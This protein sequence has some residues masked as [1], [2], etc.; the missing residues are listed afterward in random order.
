MLILAGLTYLIDFSLNRSSSRA[1]T[2]PDDDLFPR[3]VGF[4]DLV[5]RD[6][7]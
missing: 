4:C 1:T 2:F 7:T 5:A 6:G 3:R